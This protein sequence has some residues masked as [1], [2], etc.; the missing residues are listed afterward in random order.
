MDWWHNMKK[1][2]RQD[3]ILKRVAA[4]EKH[5]RVSKPPATSTDRPKWRVTKLKL[6]SDGGAIEVKKK[7]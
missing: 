7:F 6:G 1:E 5:V 2:S 4:A 3:I